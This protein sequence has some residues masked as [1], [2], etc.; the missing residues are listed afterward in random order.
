MSALSGEVERVVERKLVTSIN[1]L[2][3]AFA[4]LLLAVSVT[5]ELL[6]GSLYTAILCEM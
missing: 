1:I 5:S 2:G 6:R 4:R 3:N